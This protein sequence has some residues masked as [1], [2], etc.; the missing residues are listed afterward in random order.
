MK[1][2]RQYL[3]KNI[4]IVVATP[5]R[6][7]HHKSDE[8]LFVSKVRYLVID[9]ADSLLDKDFCQDVDKILQMLSHPENV[10]TSKFSYRP[11]SIIVTAALTNKLQKAIDSRW[12]VCKNK[13]KIVIFV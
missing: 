12:S 2:Q 11:Q 13:E 9:E 7:L 6:L 8:N 1:V 5:G 4:D 10:P 3:D